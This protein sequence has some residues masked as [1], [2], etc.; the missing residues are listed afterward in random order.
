MLAMYTNI[1]CGGSF[2]AIPDTMGAV[3]YTHTT[4]ANDMSVC[5]V[6]S[7]KM[8]YRACA[9]LPKH[10][11]CHILYVCNM[12]NSKIEFRSIHTPRIVLVRQA[13]SHTT[14]VVNNMRY[15]CDQFL[16]EG[17]AGE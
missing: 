1:R 11:L 13:R 16:C 17:R 10:I 8:L 12:E 3:S 14:H 4:N 15:L 7:R 6:C 2:C 9:Y 5:C